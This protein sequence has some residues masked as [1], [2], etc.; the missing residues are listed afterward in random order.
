MSLELLT[1]LSSIGTFIVI[2]ATAVAAFWQLRHM[3]GSNSIS[4]LTEAREV[5][6]SPEFAA[7]RRFVSKELP[8]L[9]KDPETRRQLEFES[10]LPEHLQP[11]NVVGNF[12]EALG[13]WVRRGVIDQNI[14]VSLWSS[15]VVATW[16]HVTPALA[17]MRRNSGPALWDQFEYLARISQEWIDRHPDGDYPKGVAHMPVVD[18]WLA[19]DR[20]L[21]QTN[22]A[23]GETIGL[24]AAP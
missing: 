3:S 15:V 14:V 9:L 5:L 12:Y 1:A 24:R 17:I 16:H 11:L 8:R 21:A 18:E 23:V 20:R 19:E 13:S 4:T 7:A 6:E 10:P 22:G 2:A